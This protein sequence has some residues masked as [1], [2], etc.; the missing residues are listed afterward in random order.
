VEPGELDRVH[1][2]RLELDRVHL[3]RLDLELTGSR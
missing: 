3:E 1:L 2:E